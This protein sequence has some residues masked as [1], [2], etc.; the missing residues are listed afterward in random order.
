MTSTQNYFSSSKD[1]NVENIVSI[2]LYHFNTSNIIDMSSMF[3]GC[4]SLK[5]LDLSNFNTS[6]VNDMNSMFPGEP[7]DNFVM[8]VAYTE[9]I[10]EA[11]KFR[12]EVSDAFDTDVV[13]DELSTVIGCH[14]G[15]GAVAAAI[16]KKVN[17]N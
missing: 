12:A 4:S 16:Y 7:I 1:I 3:Y 5:L 17:E 8:G 15:T 11:E 13:M 10:D 9:C 6:L 14:I 2:D